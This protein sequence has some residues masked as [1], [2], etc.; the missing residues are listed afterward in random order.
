MVVSLRP[1]VNFAFGKIY[2]GA[3]LLDSLKCIHAKKELAVIDYPYIVFFLICPDVY[4]NTNIR[5]YIQ[6]DNGEVKN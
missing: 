2:Y 5:V 4:C 6:N 3:S 1:V